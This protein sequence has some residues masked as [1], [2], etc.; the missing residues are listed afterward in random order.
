[1]TEPVSGSYICRLKAVVIG[2]TGVNLWFFKTQSY[3]LVHKIGSK[4]W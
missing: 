1:M 3:W 2:T 4:V